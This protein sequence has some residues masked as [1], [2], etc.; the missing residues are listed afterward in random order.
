MNYKYS[1][2]E[3]VI[4]YLK[5]HQL[6]QLDEFEKVN[7]KEFFDENNPANIYFILFYPK[8]E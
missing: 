2:E 7:F 6:T 8:K 1:T 4:C 3:A 5:N